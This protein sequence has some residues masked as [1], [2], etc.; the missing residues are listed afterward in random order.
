MP[1][2]SVDVGKRA[3]VTAGILGAL[4]VLGEFCFLFPHLL[5]SH[6]AMP[7]YR[8]HMALMRG[9]LQGTILTTFVLGAASVMLIR[10]KVYGLAG[11]ALGVIAILLGGSK[12]E[13]ITNRPRAI[14]AGLDYFCLELLVLG[15]VFIPMERI[16]SL[17]EQKIFRRGWQTDLKHFFASHAGVQ[18]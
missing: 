6:D 5:V 9:I 11:I 12:A 10:S 7:L 14:S 8:E 15:M 16:W 13:A 18:L 1:M 17:H 3:G 4:C 2:R